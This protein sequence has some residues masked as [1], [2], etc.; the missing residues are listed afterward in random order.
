MTGA[1]KKKILK[2]GSITWGFYVELEKNAQGKRV[3]K[4]REGFKTKR[5]AADSLRIVIGDRNNVVKKSD[6]RSF[7]Y[8]L[9]HWL[10]TH[11]EA[12]L[13]KLTA[14]RYRDLAAYFD[15]VVGQ[16]PMNEFRTVDLEKIFA[17]L[18]EHGGKNGR[19]LAPK[20]IRNMSSVVNC[21]F[22]EAIRLEIIDHNP[23]RSVRLPRYVKAE[24]KV[25]EESQLDALISAASGTPWLR[26]LLLLDANTG[27]RRGELLATT[28][29][30]FDF[31]R[32][33]LR[34]TKSLGQTR[35]DIYLKTTKNRRARAVTLPEG[36][37]RE[38]IAYRAE[39]AR[40][41]AE[42]GPGY[43]HDLNLVLANATGDY[44]K[45]DSVSAK[46]SLLARRLCLRA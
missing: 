1:I 35:Q 19:A 30:D 2:D 4:T 44:L 42:V 14:K 6:T 16:K 28:W 13:E 45:P 5:E 3:Q 9:Q 34:L 23:M 43:R 33:I 29:A 12:R 22:E 17:K 27:C 21:V 18:Q 8:V 36:L 24:S 11:A 25:L 10:K 46:V 20:T 32:R 7:S 41:A 31:D 38:L 26:M 37:L 40:W 15:A 39:Q